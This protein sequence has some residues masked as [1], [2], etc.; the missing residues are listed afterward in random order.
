MLE[1]LTV[2]RMNFW[3]GIRQGEILSPYLFVILMD[4]IVTNDRPPNKCKYS[5]TTESMHVQF[6]FS[7]A[8]L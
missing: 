8:V 3:Q 5:L 2:F 1:L 6:D 7:L 4:E